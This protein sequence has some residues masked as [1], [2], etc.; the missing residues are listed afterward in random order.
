MGTPKTPEPVPA[1]SIPDDD[2][3]G[4]LTKAEAA[5]FMGVSVDVI[6]RLARA[7]RLHPEKD[8]E[9]RNKYDPSELNDCKMRDAAIPIRSAERVQTAHDMRREQFAE[10]ELSTVKA[11]LGMIDKPREK[12]DDLLFRTISRLEAENVMLRGELTKG[13]Q[14]VEEA[15]DTTAERNVAM[16]LVTNES[17]VKRIAAERIIGTVASMFAKGGGVSLTSEQL[18]E[19]VLVEDFLTPEQKKQAQ[20]AIVAQSPAKKTVETKPETKPEAKPEAA[21]EGEPKP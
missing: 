16:S 6:N 5:E 1:P 17:A 20:Q 19:L 18:R 12:I 15:L 4:W 3:E 13:R 14:Q 11:L 21:P 9:G 7:G 10:Y 8:S 2:L